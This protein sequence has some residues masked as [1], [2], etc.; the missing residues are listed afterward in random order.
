MIDAGTT[1]TLD[2][3]STFTTQ[4]NFTFNNDKQIV[5]RLHRSSSSNRKTKGG[6]LTK[7]KTNSSK[8]KSKRN[9]RYI[10]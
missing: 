9:K 3:G 10:V 7:R 6:R 1:I 4:N 2:D 5:I 8:G